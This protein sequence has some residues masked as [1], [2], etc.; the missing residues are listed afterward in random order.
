MA[1]KWH[2]NGMACFLGRDYLCIKNALTGFFDNKMT[3]FIK[4]ISPQWY[5]FR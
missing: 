1:L 3:F 2:R 4:K 5:D